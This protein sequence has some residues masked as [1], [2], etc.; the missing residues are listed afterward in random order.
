[1]IPGV[2]VE[3]LFVWLARPHSRF[4][5]PR[6][7]EEPSHG[8]RLT[9]DGTIE[10][11]DEPLCAPSSG[12]EWVA[13]HPLVGGVEGETPRGGQ[14]APFVLRTGKARFWIELP[15]GWRTLA[16]TL[17]HRY[18]GRRNAD[19]SPNWRGREG[20]LRVGDPVTISGTFYARDVRADPF[21]GDEQEGEQLPRWTVTGRAELEPGF[22]AYGSSRSSIGLFSRRWWAFVGRVGGAI[23]LGVTVFLLMIDL[24]FFN[25]PAWFD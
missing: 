12:T 10:S 17:E 23:A 11:T 3:L 9:L 20:V 8:V 24:V 2:L 18:H 16:Y 14:A 19:G 6:R 5:F 21:R 4:G 13:W 15:Y 22:M 1:L 7:V 25:R